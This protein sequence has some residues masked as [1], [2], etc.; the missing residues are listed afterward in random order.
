M[1]GYKIS[2]MKIEKINESQIRCTLTKE[3]LANRQLKISELAYGSNKAQKLFREMLQQ[4]SDEVGFEM[5]DIPL[6]IEAVPLS[7]EAIVLTVTKVP[8]PDELDTRFAQFAPS[9][10]GEQSDADGDGDEEFTYTEPSGIDGIDSEVTRL[11]RQVQEASGNFKSFRETLAEKTEEKKKSELGRTFSFSSL[12]DLCDLA[13]VLS[14]Y[15]EA[16]ASLYKDELSGLYYL[17]IEKEDLST[18]EFGRICNNASEYGNVTEG[19]QFTKRS[20]QN[21]FTL[22]S[23][24]E[25][26]A[27]LSKLV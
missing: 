20:M 16:T 13:E 24:D 1:S 4:A 26:L 5:E 15:Q 7:S 25:A 23:A 17:H 8:D 11:F 21:N 2:P 22:L 19:E 3:D 12:D 18:E 10:Q 27:M 14:S 9:L 6:M